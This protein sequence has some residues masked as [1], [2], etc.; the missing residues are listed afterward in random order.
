MSENDTNNTNGPIEI[1]RGKLYFL[2]VDD[3]NK[4]QLQNTQKNI[5]FTTDNALIYTAF[6]AD[7]GPLDLGLTYTF[8]QQLHELLKT[9][10]S[11]KKNLIYYCENHPHRRSNSVC[12]I[13]AYL[14]FVLEYSATAAYTPFF[15]IEPPLRY[16]HLCIH[17][18][19][20]IFV[21]II[22]IF[23]TEHRY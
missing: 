19:T 2:V 22:I 21:S 1:I 9:A 17:G 13:C 4:A 8:C 12:L 7:F 11:S 20:H 18:N 6:F 16:G 10:I 5:F 23:C 3:L 14:I 15:G